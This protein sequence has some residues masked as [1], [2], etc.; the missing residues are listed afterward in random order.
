MNRKRPAGDNK[1]AAITGRLLQL[2]PRPRL[3]LHFSSPL[4][5][6]VALILSAQ[7]TDERVNAVTTT[8]FRKYR[9]ARDYAEA[10]AAELEQ[11]IHPTGFYKRKARTLIACCRRLLEDFDGEV[12]RKL[13]DLTRLP[14]VGHKTANLLRACAFGEQ[15]IAV[16]T[17]VKRVSKRLGLARSDDPVRIEE[18]L[19]A[20]IPRRQWRAFTL[21]LI[22][23]GR[24]V[25]TA[26][27]PKCRECGLYA[28]C[29]WEGRE[30]RTE[31]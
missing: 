26:R 22:L 13:E 27:R 25:C 31:D 21:A 3:E 12:P 4:E 23:H 8:L 6:L 16:D 18:E 1:G 10:E 9:S 24:R 30:P 11:D 17:H 19:M 15:A 29:S 5:L 20:E 14:G 7:C 28:L 2:Y